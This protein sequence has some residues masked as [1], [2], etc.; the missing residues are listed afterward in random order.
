MRSWTARA[1]ASPPSEIVEIMNDFFRVSVR[2]VEEE[3][4]GMVTKYLGDGFIAIFGAGD[5]GSNHA[6]DAVS[7]GSEILGAVKGLNDEL[8]AKKRAPIQIGI[9]IHSG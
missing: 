6:G 7:A 1:S 8:T 2:A 9:G 3:H 5:S 4:R